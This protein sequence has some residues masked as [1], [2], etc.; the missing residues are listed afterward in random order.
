[1]GVRRGR[2]R[3]GLLRGFLLFLLLLSGRGLFAAADAQVD[4][5]PLR[6][7]N[8]AG[9]W[10][11]TPHLAYLADSSGRFSID[12]VA[13]RT[14]V[15]TFTTADGWLLPDFPSGTVCWLQ[16]SYRVDPGTS[17]EPLLIDVSWPCLQQAT[18]YWR[19]GDG[20]GWNERTLTRGD[21]EPMAFLLPRS[22]GESRRVFLRLSGN[23]ALSLPLTVMTPGRYQFR[24]GILMHLRGLCYGILLL[25]L[26]FNAYLFFR[27]RRW[28]HLWYAL[29][30]AL[31]SVY[32]LSNAYSVNALIP[33]LDGEWLFL[34]A[35]QS[36]PLMLAVA[37]AFAR[38]FLRTVQAWSRMDRLL[39]AL[40]VLS[41]LIF[42]VTLVSP[43]GIR[44][45]LVNLLSSLA[46]LLFL[47]AGIGRWY[48]GFRPARFYALAWLMLLAGVLVR[49]LTFADLLPC[50]LADRCR[51]AGAR[52]QLAKPF[53]AK[54]LA[55]ALQKATG[56]SS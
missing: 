26:C 22:G 24:A 4:P 10:V 29:Y 14:G 3:F 8:T 15:H 39:T 28:Y 16:F 41:L 2:F 33:G 25:L 11:L 51:Q 35:L 23:T 30:L 1:M 44:D 43:A 9:S 38:S 50:E 27:T 5:P 45:L 7:H 56:A 13:T 17:P 52:A 31:F 6:I 34:V 54:S 37:A 36:V 21:G 47:G 18:L 12:G 19:N 32:L 20:R 40:L 53:T 46:P 49:A 42:G 48:Q 55:A